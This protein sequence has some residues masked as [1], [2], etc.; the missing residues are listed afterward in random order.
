[1]EVWGWAGVAV[2][3]VFIVLY[4]SNVLKCNH[5]LDNYKALKLKADNLEDDKKKLTAEV[6]ALKKKCGEPQESHKKSGEKKQNKVVD[7]DSLNEKIKTLKADNDKLKEKNYSLSKDN[8]ALRK[9]IKSNSA[10]NEEDQR[11]IVSMRE[12]NA[13]LN[14]ALNE[15]KARIGA[16]EKQLAESKENAIVKKSEAGE[17]SSERAEDDVKRIAALERENASLQASLKD[18]RGELLTFKRDFKSELDVAKKEVAESNKGIKKDLNAANRQMAQAK[19]RADNNHRVYLIARAQMLL[20]EKRLMNYEPNYKPVMALPTSNEAIDEI[21]KK[22]QTLEARGNRASIDL[23]NKDK[24]ISEL[25]EKV[26]MLEAENI[27]LKASKPGS[28]LDNFSFSALE[29]DLDF[30]DE[31]LSNLVNSLGSN[32]NPL[33]SVDNEASSSLASLDVNTLVDLDFGSMDDDWKV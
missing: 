7:V 32:M 29:N 27:K 17:K 3:V 25:Q 14:V 31:S 33:E 11:E 15:A 24:A 30:E 23:S 19:K 10:S 18:V 9:D 1:M 4:V 12:Q 13:D 2:A 28:E 22:F 20:A 6:N 21:I 8:E 16:L 5:A 26:Q